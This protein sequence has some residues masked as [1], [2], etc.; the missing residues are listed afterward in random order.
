MQSSRKRVRDDGFDELELESAEVKRL[1]EDLLG[2]LDDSDA[3]SASQELYSMMRSFEDEISAPS[4]S[5][6]SP[7]AVTDP[8]L[9]SG[10]SLYQLGYLLGAS[11]C[12][13]GLPSLTA[14]SEDEASELVRVPPYSY[15]IGELWGFGS[16]DDRI[17][18]NELFGYRDP[19]SEYA[20]FDD[21][22]FGFSDGCF[23][24]SEVS[25]SFWQSGTLPA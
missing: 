7:T 15:G 14:A 3:D 21:G 22:L 6:S 11:D 10:E 20:A 4:T 23:D 9:D 12:E 18:C 8:K 25:D 5:S 2:V 24:P 19:D 17:P 13:L 1:R 16:F